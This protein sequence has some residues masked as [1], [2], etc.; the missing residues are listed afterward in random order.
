MHEHV[1]RKKYFTSS[2]IVQIPVVGWKRWP[3]CCQTEGQR[4]PRRNLML[5]LKVY[6]LNTGGSL[7]GY[8][9]IRPRHHPTGKPV[10][11][12]SYYIIV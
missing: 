5:P 3:V 2:S 12:W 6:K 4:K 10:Q 9:A 11:I 8:V 7:T 1:T